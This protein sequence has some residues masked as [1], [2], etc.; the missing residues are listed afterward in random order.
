LRNQNLAKLTSSRIK[1][2]RTWPITHFFNPI[3]TCTRSEFQGR[4]D[5]VRNRNLEELTTPKNNME[6]N[7]NSLSL[8]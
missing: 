2:I 5:E 7:M 3:L 6:E 8:L 4:K 1:Q